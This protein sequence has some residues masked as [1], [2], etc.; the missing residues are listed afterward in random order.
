[1]YNKRRGKHKTKKKGFVLLARQIAKIKDKGK[2]MDKVITIVSG[3][4]RSGTSM[5]MKILETGGIE[6][7][8]DGVRK[9][10]EDNPHGYYE[11]EMVKKI[12]YDT[13]WQKEARGKAFKMISQ[14]LFELPPD[15]DYKVIFMKRKMHE[16]LA[17]QNKMLDRRGSSRGGVSDEKMGEFFNN[18][19]SKIMKW[20]EER[21]NIS[22]LYIEYS[23]FF[24]NP[25][26]EIATINQFL[27]NRLNEE[28]AVTAIDESLYRNR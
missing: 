12:G 13:G 17:S 9:A 21:E 24:I 3:L 20:I 7:M 8:T 6:V 25:Y 15:E 4:P 28:K 10:D 11:Y 18:H 26:K 1:M 5:M 16:I 27:N 14:L 19:L 22:V 23:N 2:Q